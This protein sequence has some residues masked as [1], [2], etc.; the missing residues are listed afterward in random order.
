VNFYQGPFD[1]MLGAYET[2][3]TPFTLMRWDQNDNP[4]GAAG[5]G[6]QVAIGGIG[7]ESLEEL[8]E[9]Y[10]FEGA[11]A[12]YQSRIGD[13]TIIYA[14]PEMASETETY[15][16]HMYGGHGRIILPYTRGFSTLTIGFTGIRA[17]DDT[18][19]ADQATYDPMQSDVFGVDINI[20]LFWNLSCFGEYARSIR[21][22]NLL[23]NIDVI[24]SENGIM[25]GLKIA[26]SDVFDANALYMQLDPYFSPLYR[27]LSYAKNRRGFRGAF[28]FRKIPLFSNILSVSLYAKLLREIKPTWNETITEWH[29]SLSDQGVGN[30]AATYSFW[31]RWKAESSYEYR[32]TQRGDD[33]TTLADELID[34]QTHVISLALYYE[35]TL[36]TKIMLKY[37]WINNIDGTGQNDYLAHIPML[38][39]IFKF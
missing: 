22:D 25:A 29:S 27:A 8:K 15:K 36:Q 35:F 17:Q 31:D 24:H 34:L 14:R 3:F 33:G 26:H 21:D 28:T 9:D 20:P 23:S 1:V 4:L 11:K 37:Q 30:V 5:C 2:S 12:K 10:R 6:C 13:V 19:S 32:R 38:Q 39:F 18:L 7:L 16:R